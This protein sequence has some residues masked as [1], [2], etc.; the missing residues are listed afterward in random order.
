MVRRALLKMHTALPIAVRVI[1][2]SCLVGFVPAV[3]L[4]HIYKH[5]FQRF[6]NNQQG[7]FVLWIWPEDHTFALSW[8]ICRAID[9]E[10]IVTCHR[11]DMNVV[12]YTDVVVCLAVA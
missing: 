4:G 10:M 9:R 11:L 6:N 5:K 12:L 1:L 7:I 3:S 2:F 8:E